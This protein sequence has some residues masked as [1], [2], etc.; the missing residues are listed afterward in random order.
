MSGAKILDFCGE[1][2][3]GRGVERGGYC[4]EKVDDECSSAVPEMKF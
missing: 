4:L 2:G 1:D 3:R